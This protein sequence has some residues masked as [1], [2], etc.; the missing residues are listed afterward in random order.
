MSCVPH[1]QSSKP[2]GS[3]PESN[4]LRA[5]FQRGCARNNVAAAFVARKMAVLTWHSLG[6]TTP[7]PVWCPRPRSRDLEPLAELPAPRRPTGA[8]HAY[9]VSTARAKEDSTPSWLSTIDER[10][11][12]RGKMRPRIG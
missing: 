8:A 12:V 9:N 4:P 3:G 7:G 10:T 1:G 2:Q 5:L 11:N 6:R